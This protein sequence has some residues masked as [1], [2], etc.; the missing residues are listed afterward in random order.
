MK[1][2]GGSLIAL[3]GKD[4]YKCRH[5]K[6]R[7]SI[8]D[9]LTG[10]HKSRY[11]N[12]R[13]SY[14][15]ACKEITAF[16]E[17][18]KT[19]RRLVSDIPTFEQLVNE[20]TAHKQA[21]GIITSETAT[22]QKSCLKLLNMHLGKYKVNTIKP[23]MVTDACKMLLAGNSPSGKPCSGTY[24]NKAAT[25]A[26]GMYEYAIKHRYTLY[27]PIKDA[28]IPKKDTKEKKALTDEQIEKLNT[29][30]EPNERHLVA[31]KT[32]L[33]SG[34]RIGEVC[35][36]RWRDIDFDQ[37]FISVSAS[38]TK[39]GTIKDT[40]TSASNDVVPM[41]DLLVGFLKTWKDCQAAKMNELELVQD[42][43]T[44][45]LANRFGDPI[46]PGQL[47]RWWKQHRAKYGLKDTVFHELRH[48]YITMLGRNNTDP[49]VMQ[50]L[51]R[52]ATM[53]TTMGIYNHVNLEQRRAAVEKFD[54]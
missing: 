45:V 40:K 39:Q 12:F 35:A 34:L 25:L 28:E 8:K 11:K 19:E 13:G 33:Y 14:S 37:R 20:Y 16:A 3:D 43:D 2:N 1:T 38:M 54:E 22:K 47:S 6:M 53:D 51:A 26:N 30:L 18:V 24:V 42:D 4:K 31:V 50:R 41:P 10:K 29:Y 49:Y 23:F 36:L 5:W 27:N 52:H 48:T 21:M 32:S 7:I 15:D 17:K 44:F 9:E 46:N